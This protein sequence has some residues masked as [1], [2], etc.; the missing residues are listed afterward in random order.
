[1]EEEQQR[2]CYSGQRKPK[3]SVEVVGSVE[4]VVERTEV[5]TAVGSAE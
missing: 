3:N 2:H 5:V 1:M 4:W